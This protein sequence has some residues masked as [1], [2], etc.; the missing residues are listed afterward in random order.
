MIKF[1]EYRNKLLCEA[2]LGRI[3]QHTKNANLG[4]ISAERGMYSKKEN[5]K[6]SK[7]LEKL[8]KQAGFGYIHLKGFW[9]ENSGTDNEKH[10]SEKSYMIIAKKDKKDLLK[11]K[12]K[13]WGSEDYFRQEA[14][15]FKPY[16]SEEFL[17]IGTSDTVLVNDNGEEKEVKSFISKGEEENIGKFRPNQISDLYLKVKGKPFT[18]ESVREEREAD[19]FMSAMA[20]KVVQEYESGLREI[21]T[22]KE[23]VDDEAFWV[24][25]DTIYALN[26]KTHIDYVLANPEKFGYKREDIEKIYKKYDE[27]LG[28]EGK[29]RDEIIMNLFSKNWIR[30]RKY[31]RNPFY[32]SIQTG[33]WIKN[34]K[35][36][37]NF[38]LWAIT[39][40]IMK[41]NADARV[42]AF[43]DE[44]CKTYNFQNGG[45]KKILDENIDFLK[46]NVM[47]FIVR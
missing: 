12:L 33:S 2:S 44:Y 42:V 43:E 6:R 25:G 23:S 18:I 5:F 27:R 29:A 8:I 1:T 39:E 45:I 38:V 19:S 4:I 31:T 34:K 15:V 3:L 22:I 36:I 10:I 14:V 40:E 30:V 17:L 32:W 13:L 24:K 28:V 20:K 41:P 37:I 16:D 26:G 9:V 47:N 21:K 7:E 46:E 35:T 11:E